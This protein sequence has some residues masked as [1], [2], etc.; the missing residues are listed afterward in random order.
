MVSLNSWVSQPSFAVGAIV[1]TALAQRTSVAT[2][3][4]VAAAVLA[5]AAPLYLPAWWQA[6]ADRSSAQQ[7][8]EIGP[9]A[10]ETTT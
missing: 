7:S 5:A 10:V 4:L 3:I 8:V 2:A 6:R 1:L 9:S